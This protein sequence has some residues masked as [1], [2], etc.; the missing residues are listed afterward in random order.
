[1]A[2]ESPKQRTLPSCTSSPTVPDVFDRHLR[3]DTV[4]VEQVEP[5]DPDRLREAV[6]T[7]RICSGLLSSP[8]GAPSS[9]WNPN[10]VAITTWS[11]N[12][13]RASPTSSSLT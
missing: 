11:R 2:S 8:A 13:A 12:G 3:I 10:L 1:M 6:A 7:A 5:L 9:M 4:L